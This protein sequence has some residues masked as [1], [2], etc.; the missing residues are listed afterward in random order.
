MESRNYAE[1]LTEMKQSMIAGNSQITDFNEGSNIMTIFESVA[2][3]IEQGYIDTRNGYNNNLRAIPYA[4]FDFKKKEGVKA[5]VDVK[6]TR[7]AATDM[8]STIPAN[9][10]VSDGAGHVFITSSVAV[11][12]AEATVSNE[13]GAIAE[14][15]GLEYRYTYDSENSL[16]ILDILLIKDAQYK[17]AVSIYMYSDTTVY[18]VT[19]YDF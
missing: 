16:V 11:I 8:E 14:N 18:D 9:T 1:L 4:V 19:M 12:A 13:V 2:R 5:T 15:V 17:Y 7:N 10:R 3:P 6:F